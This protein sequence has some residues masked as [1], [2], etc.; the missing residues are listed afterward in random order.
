MELDRCA[1][2]PGLQRRIKNKRIL[3]ELEEVIVEC[4]SDADVCV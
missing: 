2:R 4:L 3:K 1:T